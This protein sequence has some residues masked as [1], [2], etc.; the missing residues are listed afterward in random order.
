L[1]TATFTA[2]IQILQLRNSGALLGLACGT[3]RKW[4]IAASPI[5]G[6]VVWFHYNKLLDVYVN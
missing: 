3:K 6:M 1:L 2:E 5:S 4:E